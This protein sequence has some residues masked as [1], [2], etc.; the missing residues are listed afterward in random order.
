M[1]L[2]KM[3]VFQCLQGIGALFVNL[4]EYQG[5]YFPFVVALRGIT[6]STIWFR[7]RFFRYASDIFVTDIRLYDTL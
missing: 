2:R 3:P 7:K 4:S 1:F 6:W 5:F